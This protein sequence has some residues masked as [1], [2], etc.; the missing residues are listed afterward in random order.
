MHSKIVVLLRF[1][2]GFLVSFLH[3]QSVA[4][5][6]CALSLDRSIRPKFLSPFGRRRRQ[7]PPSSAWRFG[8]GEGEKGQQSPRWERKGGRAIN[9]KP[10][11]ALI[12]LCRAK[13]QLALS[14]PKLFL[15]VF[16]FHF[17]EMEVLQLTTNLYYLWACHILCR[18][19]LRKYLE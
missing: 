3:F 10:P 14:L 8:T 5:F 19:S 2:N 13:S 12:V 1:R 15:S 7:R 11:P 18:E 17:I 4:L 6:G 9:G 16:L